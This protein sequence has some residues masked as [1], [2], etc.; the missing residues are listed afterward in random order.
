[1]VMRLMPGTGFKPKREIALR[2]FFSLRFCLEAPSP[3]GPS[4]A[5]NSAKIQSRN[6]MTVMSSNAGWHERQQRLGTR[7]ERIAKKTVL[8]A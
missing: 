7:A 4:A 6:C 2:A 1:M 3:A 5:A 8:T